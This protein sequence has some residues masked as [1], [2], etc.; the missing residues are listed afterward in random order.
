[1]IRTL[2]DKQF[3]KL[4]KDMTSRKSKKSHKTDHN[5][6]TER[7]TRSNMKPIQKKKSNTD[8]SDNNMPPKKNKG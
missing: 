7:N 1:M 3:E 6:S 2:I 5:L 8:M 4:K